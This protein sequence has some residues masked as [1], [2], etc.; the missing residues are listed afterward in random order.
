MHPLKQNYGATFLTKYLI[1]RVENVYQIEVSVV[2]TCSCR[3]QLNEHE[4]FSADIL[5]PRPVAADILSVFSGVRTFPT[6]PPEFYLL[7]KPW[8]E[9]SVPSS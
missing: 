5:G 8:M 9:N 3:V 6:A 7:Q 4:Y 1:C 2:A